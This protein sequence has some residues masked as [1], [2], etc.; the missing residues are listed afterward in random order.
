MRW[1][2]ISVLVIA[3]AP[4]VAA[5]QA[6]QPP[7]TADEEIPQQNVPLIEQ[8]L[9]MAPKPDDWIKF[10]PDQMRIAWAAPSTQPNLVVVMID[11][12][13]GPDID[14]IFDSIIFSENGHHVAYVANKG[15]K[16]IVMM[17]GKE[18]GGSSG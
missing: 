5:Q 18:R 17:D 1:R 7:Q 16:Q 3:L 2:A 11:G 14:A 13:P 4:F 15:P 12:K 10:G 6:L 8:R 9:G